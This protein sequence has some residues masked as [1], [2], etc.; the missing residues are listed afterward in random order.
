MADGTIHQIEN[1]Y[2]V[3]VIPLSETNWTSNRS[4]LPIHHHA[5]QRLLPRWAIFPYFSRSDDL[6]E[7][8]G[9]NDLDD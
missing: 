6:E 9:L 7:R 8:E 2:M 1:H 3:T 4:F 5:L